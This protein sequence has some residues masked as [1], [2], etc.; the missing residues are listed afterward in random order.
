MTTQFEEVIRKFQIEGEI[1]DVATVSHGAVNQTFVV[2]CGGERYILQEMNRVVFKYPTEVMNNLSL[3]TSYLRDVIADEGL[4][5]DRETPHFIRTSSGN[6]ILQTDSG[7]Y[8]RL[9]RMIPS[10]GAMKKPA[11]AEEAC[12]VGR[13]L[14]QF[15]RRLRGF[16]TEQ[17]SRPIPNLHDMPKV[18]RAFTDAVR[19]DICFR[20]ANCQEQI[21]FVLDRSEKIHFIRDAVRD[22]EIPLRVNHNDPHYKNILT[23]AATGRALCLIDL[24]TVM[25]G[26]SILDLGDAVRINAATVSEEETS[27]DV[28][29]MLD[30]F[31]GLLGGYAGQ[32]NRVLTPREWEL[33]GYAVWLVTFERGIGYL[34]DYL[35]G[36][37]NATD[38]SDE[39]RNLY[40]AVN[41]FY[42]TLDA[43]EKMEEM[44]RI[45][46]KV[47]DEV[48]A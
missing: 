23:D 18:M 24:D 43:E 32:M 20:S 48:E 11:S 36:E 12:E 26:V 9:Y 4:D 6:L 30:R 27:G 1:T 46:D 33:I 34:T 2:T 13:M 17:L 19:S 25:P 42:L 7:R 10:G 22:G 41:Q 29:L 21:R 37:Q 39:R 8:F 3:V 31:E 47:R 35:N 45:V 40:R 28:E 14:G 44:N 38:F 16:P 5:P 15:H